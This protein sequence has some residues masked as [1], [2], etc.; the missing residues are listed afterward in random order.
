MRLLDEPYT[1]PPDDGGRRMTAWV[2]RA[3]SHVKHKRVARL[4]QPRG[5]EAMYPKPRLRQTPP[6]QRVSPY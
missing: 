1:L 4:R 3:G 2:R 5:S 6:R